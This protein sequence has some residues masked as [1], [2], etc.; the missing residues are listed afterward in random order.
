M[1]GE[2]YLRRHHWKIFFGPVNP[3]PSKHPHAIYD[4]AGE[5]ACRL[6]GAE[7]EMALSH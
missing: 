5:V 2:N 6:V 7:N 3:K 1:N 4:G